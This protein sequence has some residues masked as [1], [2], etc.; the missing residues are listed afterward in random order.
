MWKAFHHPDISIPVVRRRIGREVLEL[1]EFMGDMAVHHV[2]AFLRN[3][4]YPD[5]SAYY[6]A[7]SRL[8]KQGLIVKKQGLKT[9]SLTI[10]DEGSDSL[11]AC[12]FPE[13]WWNR[14]WNGIWYVLVYDI[15]ETDRPY[16]NILR[17]F[18]KSQRMGCFQKS[19]W[20][21]P[22]DIRPLYSDLQEAAG[23]ST[24]ACLFEARTVLGMPAEKVVLTTWNFDQL[25]NMQNR[26]C[27][28]YSENLQV[29]RKI[30][31]PGLDD[32][33]RLA[34]EEMNAFRS[35]FALDPLLPSALLPE[36][37]MGKEAYA[38]HLEVGKVIRKRIQ[39][40]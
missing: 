14:T 27:D 16:R 4:S 26:F 39:D 25:F 21:T 35:V 5:R 40:L 22:H 36:N 38:I 7:V 17:Q 34:A 11:K 15:P 30:V 12:L 29:L 28:I 9:S 6:S 1:L 3:D 32:L 2:Y 8:S 31:M 13:R 19:V 33:M 23:L 37:Y 18:L 20:V 24:F 10:S